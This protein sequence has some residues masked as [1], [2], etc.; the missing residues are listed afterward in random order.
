MISAA[1]QA[2]TGV[3]TF[4]TW[5]PMSYD[6]LRARVT[7]LDQ[8]AAYNSVD[9]QL[10]GHGEPVRLAAAE[11]S[12]NLFDL[13]G[14]RPLLGRPL[15]AEDNEPG[16]TNVVMLSYSLWQQRLGGPIGKL[17][18]MS[19]YFVT[20]TWAGLVAWKRALLDERAPVWEPTPR[21]VG[22]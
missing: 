12:G 18:A 7:T 21:A 20:G 3:K 1:Q 5:A 11:V 14:V 16:K 9:A 22:S 2:E 10:T 6:G 13:L 8:I 15:R 17:C 4:S 19:A